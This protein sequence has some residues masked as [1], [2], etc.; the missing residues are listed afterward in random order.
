MQEAGLGSG[1]EFHFQCIVILPRNA[2]AS[3]LS[4]DA[5][6]AVGFA[7]LTCGLILRGIPRVCDSKGFDRTWNTV[8]VAFSRRDHS[9]LPVFSDDGYPRTG[10]IGR[11]G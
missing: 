3:G 11:Y 2:Q 5:H 6:C 9:V 7:L 8:I 4:H 10:D 1:G